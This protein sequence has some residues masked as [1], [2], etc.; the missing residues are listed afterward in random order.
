MK[1]S[2]K[3]I[4]DDKYILEICFNC[5]NFS[6]VYNTCR[7]GRFVNLNYPYPCK[8]YSNKYYMQKRG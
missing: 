3:E 4:I 6:E 1:V 8:D 2:G 7:L 5:R